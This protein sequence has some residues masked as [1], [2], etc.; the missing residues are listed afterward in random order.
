V[1]VDLRAVKRGFLYAMIVSIV[2]AGLFAIVTFLSGGISD[3]EGRIL[4]TTL[5]LALSSGI[6]LAASTAWLK[7]RPLTGT[8]IAAAGVAFL[9]AAPN[10]W[11][12]ASS[13]AWGKTIGILYIVAVAGAYASLLVAFRREGERSSTSAVHWLAL[14][15]LAWLTAMAIAFIVSDYSGDNGFRAVGVA[16]VLLVASTLVTVLLRRLET[17]GEEAEP[18][19]LR[20]RRIERIEE[21]E[22]GTV[23]VLDDGRRL[24]LAPGTTID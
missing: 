24:P 19:G 6:S 5:L 20:G 12:G 15:A 2:A 14:A 8:S 13:T 11:S 22:S 10:L 17:P 7:S 9:V 4:G 1:S 21:G 18:A 16:A 23:L 3:T